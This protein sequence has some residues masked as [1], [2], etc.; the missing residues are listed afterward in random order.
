MLFTKETILPEELSS[1]F[2]RFHADFTIN[3]RIRGLAQQPLIPA[4]LGSPAGMWYPGSLH[5]IKTQPGEQSLPINLHSGTAT[6]C[7]A[8]TS[9]ISFGMLCRVILT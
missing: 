2:I 3:Y 4:S 7:A 5:I 1:L 8:A 6:S 9:L